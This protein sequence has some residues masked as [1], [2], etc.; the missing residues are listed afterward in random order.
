M[1][2]RDVYNERVLTEAQKV[3]KDWEG[4]IKRIPILKK[5]VEI[6]K[7]LE[8][9]GQAYIVGGAV[10]DIISGEK[11]PDDIDIAT[12]VP[13]EKI[14]S[15]FKTHDIGANKD[16][17]IVVVKHKGEDF[18]IAQFRKDG[19]YTDGRRPDK[20]EV[21]ATFKGDA[22][23][24]DFTINA[25]AVDSKGNIIDH[26]D[27]QGDI[28]NK[29]LRA[30]GDPDKRFSED[31]L[32]MLR[33]VRFASRLDLQLDPEVT[34]AIQKSSIKIKD[35]APE[36]V[37]KELLKM[38]KQKGGKFADAIVK[39]DQ[40]GLLH[41]ILPE[42]VKMKEFEH[43]I[44]NHPEGGVYAHT[45]AALRASDSK[46]PIVNLSI[47]LHDIGKIKT[48]KMDEKGRIT[49][50]QH[51]KE[52]AE[53][54]DQIA[55]RLKLDTKTKNAMK[56]ATLNHMKIH[57]LLKMSNKKIIQLMNDP[58]W[59]TLLAV[60]EMDA[61]A[62]GKMFNKK[63]WDAIKVKID[64]ITRQFADK[65]TDALT[66]IRKVVTGSLIMR[67]KRIK[68]GPAVGRYIQKTVDWIADNNIN[69]KDEAK[70]KKFIKQ[71]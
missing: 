38:A 64:A 56:F 8:K 31:Y 43:D 16:F 65:G 26:F 15:L 21:V 14:E 30:V 34:T 70:I 37:T 11:K 49:Y 2:F 9:H 57:D 40:V 32:R 33:A 45:L 4:Y 67:L 5:G 22:E 20:I 52:G 46:D 7:V 3:F 19:T 54:V 27:G 28:K 29:T 23:R 71:L 48:K 50:F 61:R 55:Q 17:G 36:R 62:R 39:L 13:M 51:H 60:G 6:L 42:V 47:L 12:N 58:N 63:E 44:E 25:M 35:I 1:R 24:R 68:P 18:E 66:N 41:H 59:A 53:M 69:I 10:R